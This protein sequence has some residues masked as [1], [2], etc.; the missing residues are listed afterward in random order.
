MLSGGPDSSCIAVALAEAG[1]R[2]TCLTFVAQ[3]VASE[4]DAA[5]ALAL[6]LGHR[7]RALP[8][9]PTLDPHRLPRSLD[10]DPAAVAV[11]SIDLAFRDAV[12]EIG[13]EVV[14]SG[15]G[16]D[17]L[18]HAS[19]IALLDLVR[20]GQARAALG[21]A[22]NYHRYWRY[23]YTVL[24][25]ICARAGAPD[26]VVA[27]RERVRRH[28]PWLITPA[29]PVLAHPR[30][31]RTNLMRSLGD[32][33]L[34]IASPLQRL[35]QEVEAIVSWP[36][37][38]LRVVDLSVRLPTRLR[39][40]YPGPKPVLAEI[41]RD[42]GPALP[43]SRLPA[44][45][46]VASRAALHDLTNPLGATS[47]AVTGGLVRSAGL[48]AVADPR[49]ARDAMNLMGLEIWLTHLRDGSGSHG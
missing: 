25:K 31:D 37:C 1:I 7:W 15:E 49:W 46:R 9:R 19:P 39:I 41:L 4:A 33:Q 13:A 34:D 43:T 29:R 24:A 23:P 17:L 22:R 48:T 3:G 32:D 28:A 47:L 42:R 10:F 44:Y 2:A 38:D 26:R 20:G 14:L 27:A 16:G 6:S 40:P 30:S 5:R 11:T 12:A 8:V 18:F 35:L 21:A 36:L 45:I